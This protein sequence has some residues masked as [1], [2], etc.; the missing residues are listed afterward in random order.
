MFAFVCLFPQFHVISFDLWEENVRPLCLGRSNFPKLAFQCAIECTV[1]S[2]NDHPVP[3]WGKK[4]AF[5]SLLWFS[6]CTEEISIHVMA[7]P[8]LL[9]LYRRK[10]EM[11][12]GQHFVIL[13]RLPE[14]TFPFSYD[15]FSRM[16][17]NVWKSRVV[18]SKLSTESSPELCCI[19]NN[20]VWF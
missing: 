12:F 14:S 8:L 18:F 1:K 20:L 16:S 3:L 15:A 2:S 6:S 19:I 13:T 5:K 11:H 10:K 9:L 17:Q 7:F 4:N